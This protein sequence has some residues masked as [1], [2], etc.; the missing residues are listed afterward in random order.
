MVVNCKCKAT[1]IA[2]LKVFFVLIFDRVTTEIC[3]DP[4]QQNC[5]T[6]KY[7]LKIILR[8]VFYFIQLICFK[9]NCI[10]QGDGVYYD[11]ISYNV[12]ISRNSGIKNLYFALQFKSDFILG[13][14][15]IRERII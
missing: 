15:N 9:L 5:S 10:M 7:N 13:R 3:N 6:T 2:T 11:L 1:E 14:Q 4:P 12:Q 8:L